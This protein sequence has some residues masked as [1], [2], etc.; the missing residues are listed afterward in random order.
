MYY[1]TAFGGMS[2]FRS[3][4]IVSEVVNGKRELMSSVPAENRV[5]TTD[6]D[7]GI[8]SQEVD[9]PIVVVRSNPRFVNFWRTVC[10]D[11]MNFAS[12]VESGGRKF[13]SPWGMLGFKGLLKALIVSEAKPDD[14]DLEFL[15]MKEALEDYVGHY[16][17]FGQAEAA[18]RLASRL[19]WLVKYK[20]VDTLP[21]PIHSADL[22]RGLQMTNGSP[23]N[24]DITLTLPPRFMIGTLLI[25]G[26][27]LET[28][29]NHWVSE[30][31]DLDVA[32]T[33]RG[34]AYRQL[35]YLWE[36]GARGSVSPWNVPSMKEVNA[37]GEFLGCIRYSERGDLK[38]RGLGINTSFWEAAIVG[39]IPGTAAHAV[40]SKQ[41]PNTS[42]VGATVLSVS[43][44]W[45]AKIRASNIF[46]N[47]IFD[48]PFDDFPFPTEKIS[49]THLTEAELRFAYARK[50]LPCFELIELHFGPHRPISSFQRVLLN[51]IPTF[52][53]G[54]GMRT[55]GR[56]RDEYLSGMELSLRKQSD[57]KNMTSRA[58]S[59]TE[60]VGASGEGSVHVSPE[61]ELTDSPVEG[62]IIPVARGNDS[63]LRAFVDALRALGREANLEDMKDIARSQGWDG[64]RFVTIRD[65]ARLCKQ[66]EVGLMLE[67][68]LTGC[69]RYRGPSGIS[70]IRLAYLE[71]RQFG[72]VRERSE[73]TKGV[74]KLPGKVHFHDA[75]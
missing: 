18:S 14:G 41:Q 15:E 17:L 43:A 58:H 39:P 72:W 6:M 32:V 19:P 42:V 65:L 8:L 23:P 2:L 47:R 46:G 60:L 38:F 40:L 75:Q 4:L 66:F 9:R 64:E 59:G 49:A 44:G 51:L 74:S 16:G 61:W 1:S 31:I 5:V 50:D 25:A 67:N 37:V 29:F 73:N 12:L 21:Q 45:F 28:R 56:F 36:T 62:D 48:C 34:A 70:P 57:V 53:S 35:F 3:S 7:W 20:F 13:G 54:G 68:Q 69:L 10:G 33:S 55:G 22:V 63:A 26:H 24:E 71:N 11:G 30:N 27:L 52:P